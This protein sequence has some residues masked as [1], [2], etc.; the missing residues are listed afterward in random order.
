LRDLDVRE[1]TLYLIL[2]FILSQ[3]RD[4]RIDSDEVLEAMALA[5]RRL[6]DTL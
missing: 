3:W 2:S 6:A 1:R 5:S 4:L